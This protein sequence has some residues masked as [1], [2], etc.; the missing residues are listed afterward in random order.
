MVITLAHGA[1]G[2]E[3]AAL[4]RNVFS[5]YFTGEALSR[6]EDA[7]VVPG[8][9]TIAVNTDSFVVT[10]LVFPGGDI[11]KLAAVGTINDVLMS[12]AVPRYLTCGF[13][14]DAGLRI[15]LLDAICASLATAAAEA[16]VTVIAGDTKVIE[17]HGE[18]PGLLINTT[19]IGVAPSNPAAGIQSGDAVIL[20]GTL[21]DHH[22][23][24]LTARLGVKNNIKSDCALLAPI[25]GALSAAGIEIHAMRDV[26][27]GG[28]ATVLNEL[29]DASGVSL[30]LEEQ[31]IPVSPEVRAFCGMMGLD[32]LYM[33]NEGKMVL[34]VAE[35]DAA[36]ALEA[37]R[38]TAIGASAAIIG[39]ASQTA[40]PPP[41]SMRTLLGGTIRLS[42]L[43]GEGLPRIC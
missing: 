34:A 20:S 16:G 23:A 24:I 38:T 21:G 35:E 27:R 1:G 31:S 22:A 9:E 14:L 3:S 39:K 8:A 36:C 13:V 29:A 17:T 6:L 18:T 10:P 11:G 4:M 28:L 19:G 37:I 41:V 2:A 26:T 12:G 43:Y 25:T 5:K 30:L 33:G 42:P 40:T 32:P 15:E 7:A